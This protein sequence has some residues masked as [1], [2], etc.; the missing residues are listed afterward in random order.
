MSELLT[1][2]SPSSKSPQRIFH[3]YSSPVQRPCPIWQYLSV[4]CN[5]EL[6]R[7]NGWRRKVGSMAQRDVFEPTIWSK[8]SG[9]QVEGISRGRKR[10]LL[11]AQDFIT[12][13]RQK[14]PR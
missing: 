4:S 5:M 11:R 8:R 6:V 12:C 3:P 7:M 9:A 13:P 2:K 14:L 1:P 10:A